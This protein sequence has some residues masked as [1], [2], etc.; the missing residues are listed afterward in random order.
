MHVKQT[1]SPAGGV[2]Q[3][4]VTVCLAAITCLL[5]GC[6]QPA[7]T[8]K[9]PAFQSSENT[10]RDW[11][12]I[13]HRIASEMA[14][15]G[16]LPSSRQPVPANATLPLPVYVRAPAPGSAFLRVVASELEADILQSGGSVART[17]YG[18][19][20]VNLNVEF[21]RWSPR[22][23]PPGLIG[24]TAAIAAIPGIVIGA[25][26]PM[27]TWTAADAA[28]FAALGYG[29]FA[30]AIIA[31]TPLTNTEAIWEATIVTDDRVLLRLQEL[32]YV[33]AGDIPLYAR[34]GD[35]PLISSGGGRASAVACADD[36]L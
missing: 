21:V 31:L 22:D 2:M 16:L 27:S 14:A 10:V 30:D 17:P 4:T 7:V 35:V 34:A 24:T 26:A 11:N 32:V 5:G 15:R 23:K 6:N 1:K 9:A 29:L 36:T 18:A 13:A 20:V 19:T 12:D 28:S 3:R 25:S 8:L 33:R